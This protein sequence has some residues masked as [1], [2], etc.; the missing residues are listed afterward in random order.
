MGP[1]SAATFHKLTGGVE[2]FSIQ[3]NRQTIGLSGIKPYDVVTYDDLSNT[4]IVSDLRLTCMLAVS[5]T[6]LTRAC[7]PSKYIST[8]RPP[9][10]TARPSTDVTNP[11]QFQCQP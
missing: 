3:K 7:W 2:N 4:L 6:H 11:P 1:A 10:V 9:T 5:Y 8:H